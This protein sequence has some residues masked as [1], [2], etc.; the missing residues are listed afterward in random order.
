MAED[1]KI[2]IELRISYEYGSNMKRKILAC[3][4]IAVDYT[5]FKTIK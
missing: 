4:N 2:T 5:L 1:V 3:D